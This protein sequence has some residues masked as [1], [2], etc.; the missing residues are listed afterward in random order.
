VTVLLDSTILIAHLRGDERATELIAAQPRAETL[1][2]VLSR[3]E[4][5]G[6]MRSHERRGVA[7]LF[8]T[9]TTREVTDLIASQAGSWLRRYRASHP[10]IDLVDY[11]IAAT[12]RENHAR[13]VTL[14]VEHFPMF[15]DLEPP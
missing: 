2:S 12:A 10:G 11:L 13:L 4:I 1:V 14:N 5:E 3:T 9:V 6:F 15:E 8:N 7:R